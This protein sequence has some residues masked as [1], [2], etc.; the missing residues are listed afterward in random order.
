MDLELG[1]ILTKV[2]LSDDV[3][4]PNN[5]KP[6]RLM[7]VFTQKLNDDGMINRYKA[8]LVVLENIQVHGVDYF[9]TYAPVGMTAT[10]RL[11]FSAVVARNMHCHQT[12]AVTAFLN[13]KLDERLFVRLDEATTAM[14]QRLTL[15]LGLRRLNGNPVEP[16]ARALYRAAQA[17]AV[18]N[19]E[20]SGYLRSIGFTQHP[21]D[22]CLL[23]RG[24]GRMK[25]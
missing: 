11:L 22:P 19:K 10:Y 9:D 8:R 1:S 16:L 5:T 4:F 2:T 3:R 21:D 7:W 23:R 20:V 18:W 6:L 24:S 25:C 15:S 14:V 17:P 13:A 12:D